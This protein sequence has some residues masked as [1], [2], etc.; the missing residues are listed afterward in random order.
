M[1]KCCHPLK[2]KS[3]IIIRRKCKKGCEPF[4]GLLYETEA[5]IMSAPVGFSTDTGSFPVSTRLYK[6]TK[7]NLEKRLKSLALKLY[8]SLSLSTLLCFGLLP[9]CF[10]VF[11]CKL[12]L[13]TQIW[14]KQICVHADRE[15]WIF[16]TKRAAIKWEKKPRFWS[17]IPRW[18]NIIRA[19]ADHENKRFGRFCFW[20]FSSTLPGFCFHICTCLFTVY[21]KY[22]SV[23]IFLYIIWA[24]SAG[25][26]IL[27]VRN[28]VHKQITPSGHGI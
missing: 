4:K 12:F 18:V 17:C 5:E 6:K 1:I 27:S 20:F 11:S 10:T 22:G 15:R 25:Q 26:I 7:K 19:N 21:R 3:R 16:A 2:K 24:N 13:T 28:R 23:S 14:W 8:L 9:K